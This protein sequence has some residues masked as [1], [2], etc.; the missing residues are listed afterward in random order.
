MGSSGRPDPNRQTDT[1]TDRQ[2]DRRKKNLEN[3]LAYLEL[4][5]RHPSQA[6]EV[7][8][9]EKRILRRE[10]SP[11]NYPEGELRGIQLPDGA[12]KDPYSKPA[13][14]PARTKYIHLPE[15]MNES[16]TSTSPPDA[17][18][19]IQLPER[20]HFIGLIVTKPT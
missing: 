3:A 2:T 6:T 20:F 9:T 19:P 5:Y 16:Q 14:V 12:K 7:N 1:Q 8:Q 13:R 18:A 11:D 10:T 15:P 17:S 4:P